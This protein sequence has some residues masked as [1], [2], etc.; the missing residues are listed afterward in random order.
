LELSGVSTH[1]LLCNGAS[2]T[3][4]GAEEVTKAIRGEI[5]NQ[6]LTKQI[7]TTRTLCNG[8]CKDGPTVVVY[9]DGDWYKNMTPEL[10]CELVNQLK[11][12][13]R[14]EDS[15]SY[16][17]DGKKFVRSEDNQEAN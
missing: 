9:P 3:R 5:K 4:K 10:G 15:V 12:D 17:Y 1:V 11:H 8:R 7:H 2:C 13:K 14:L 16:S 6:G